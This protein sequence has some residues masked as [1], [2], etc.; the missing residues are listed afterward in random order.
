[1][2]CSNINSSDL[3]SVRLPAMYLDFSTSSRRL[4]DLCFFTVMR[5]GLKGGVVAVDVYH[6]INSSVLWAGL[7]LGVSQRE[8][9]L[10][11][12]FDVDK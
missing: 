10:I 8:V 2:Q 6:S 9:R 3:L 12:D 5:I 1:M 7:K 4:W 11:C